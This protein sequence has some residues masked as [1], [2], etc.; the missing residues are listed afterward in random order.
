[1][2]TKLA[3]LFDEAK[4]NAFGKTTMLNVATASMLHINITESNQSYDF[5]F[6]AC[7]EE[8]TNAI[9]YILL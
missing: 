6:F 7:K 3:I 9:F 2:I 1:M 5:F 4:L 8:K